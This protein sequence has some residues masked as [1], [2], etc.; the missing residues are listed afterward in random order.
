[1]VPG[2]LPAELESSVARL[3]ALLDARRAGRRAT[4]VLG[5]LF[6]RG[7]CT[8]A[9]W[10][11]AVGVG[12]DFPAYYYFLGS[13]GRKADSVAAALGG[14]AVRLITPGD[15]LLFGLDDTP[16]QRYGPKVQ[17]AGIHHHPTPGPADQTFLDGHVWV[18]RAW[19]V[20]HPRW[21]CSGLPLRA[22]LYVRPH[23]IAKLP[24]RTHGKFRTKLVMAAALIAWGADR[25]Q[26][27]GKTVGVVVDGA[28]GKR[29]VLPKAKA[30]K[31]V[32]VRR[33]RKDARLFAVPKPPRRR[34]PGR[35]RTY[36]APLS[37][38]RR[39]A[40]PRG[41]QTD[42]FTLSGETV[43]QTF[44]TVV[45]TY[46]PAGGAIGVV[47]VK[48]TTGWVAFFATDPSA[49]VAQV[50]AA[51]ADRAAIAQDCRDRK[52][53][54]GAGQQHVR[55]SWANGATWHLNLWLHPRI[56]WWG[57][58]RP[59]AELCDRT[60]SPWDDAAWRPSH[61]DRR[62]ALRRRCLEQEFDAAEAQQRLSR[63][64][65]TLFTGLLRL[66]G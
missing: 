58:A 28:Y 65:R 3:A 45:A 22:L 15:R 8:V 66:A 25:L 5:M 59:K 39:G 12:H 16:T 35:V 51:V 19:L 64:L 56:E 62:N 47:I 30:Q 6:A 60:R 4:V 2:K 36:G 37:L 63:K 57:W 9:S 1:M 32:I 48:E 10:L 49:T 40:H 52:E 17:G 50:L 18:T 14:L 44:T 7:R 42:T 34:G 27:R 21:A 11:R 20:R 46:P 13:L 31:V 26:G 33:L 43:T 61:A 38:A 24:R 54:Q 41:W 29:P 53:V 23:D 55:S